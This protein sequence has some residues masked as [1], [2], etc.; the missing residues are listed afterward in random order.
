MGL[1]TPKGIRPGC[2]GVRSVSPAATN[3]THAAMSPVGTL[4]SASKRLTGFSGSAVVVSSAMV[5]TNTPFT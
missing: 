4:T 5:S 3:T 2:T 1:V